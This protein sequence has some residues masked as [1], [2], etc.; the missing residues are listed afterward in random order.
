M[1]T[2]QLGGMF[3][4]LEGLDVVHENL[5]GADGEQVTALGA[6]AFGQ[7]LQEQLIQDNGGSLAQEQ[8]VLRQLGQPMSMAMSGIIGTGEAG[9]LPGLEN[10]L[11]DQQNVQAS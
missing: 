3:E 1:T 8:H 10:L 9:G 6:S 5:R 2:S 4:G 11:N 7:P